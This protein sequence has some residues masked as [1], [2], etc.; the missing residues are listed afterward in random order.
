MY[1]VLA[2][3]NLFVS[4]IHF[5]KRWFTYCLLS[6]Y[7]WYEIFITAICRFANF[8]VLIKNGSMYRNLKP[9]Q[10]AVGYSFQ[11]CNRTY[12][13]KNSSDCSINLNY[14]FASVW[15]MLANKFLLYKQWLINNI[16]RVFLEPL[17]QIYITTHTHTR[18]SFFVQHKPRITANIL[19]QIQK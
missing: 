17:L 6:I 5:C 13:K 16:L 2:S 19:A 18:I 10:M 1:C 12:N 8:T 9:L 4:F 7:F 11:R 3:F 14:C 15:F